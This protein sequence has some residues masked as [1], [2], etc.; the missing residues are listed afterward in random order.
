MQAEKSYSAQEWIAANHAAEAARSEV[1]A[2]VAQENAARFAEVKTA[3]EEAQETIL[4][5]LEGVG[6]A[7][8]EKLDKQDEFHHRENVRVYRNVQASLVSELEKQ[9]ADLKQELARLQ[10]ALEAERA[11]N[12]KR[13]SPLLWA[14]FAGVMAVL[15]I[16]VLD[17]TGILA[18]L[19][20]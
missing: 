12:K 17:F 7:I 11:Q 16:E 1:L 13:R 15:A 5:S 9:T 8:S 3:Q 10:Q 20:I 2:T 18:Y 6:S 14:T 4:T 19:I